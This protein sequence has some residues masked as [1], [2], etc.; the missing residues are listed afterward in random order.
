MDRPRPYTPAPDG[1]PCEAAE[2][3]GKQGS[4][5]AWARR[6]EEIASDEIDEADVCELGSDAALAQRR[7]ERAAARAYE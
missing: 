4:Q 3:Q 2:G 1:H 5:F 6:G 7:R